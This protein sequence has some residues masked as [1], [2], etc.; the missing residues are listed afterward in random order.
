M[1]MNTERERMKLVL[2]AA[3]ALVLAG[4]CVAQEEAPSKPVELEVLKASL[5][6]WDAEVEVWSAGPDAPTTKFK[7]VETNSACGEHWI[8]S[9]FE[10]D[11]N[12]QT[13]KVHAIIGYDLDQKKLIGTMVDHGPYAAKMTGGY[14]PETKT[15]AWTT[16]AKD[17]D[18]TPMVQKTTLV[19]KSADERELVMKVPGKEGEEPTK[20]MH[21]KFTKRK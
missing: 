20:F 9:E 11:Y 15:V 4:A 17:F 2:T 16:L 1:F 5:G 18:G 21:I 13:M 14:D 3:L 19:Q 6:V 7:G 10:S 12:G 8:A